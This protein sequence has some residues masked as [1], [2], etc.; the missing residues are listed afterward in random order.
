MIDD[1]FIVALY[2]RFF[3][4]HWIDA[5]IEIRGYNNQEPSIA[6]RM[7]I[8]FNVE[9]ISIGHYGMNWTEISTS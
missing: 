3:G 1:L 9:L 8:Y 4:F 7:F 5:C 2:C 6:R